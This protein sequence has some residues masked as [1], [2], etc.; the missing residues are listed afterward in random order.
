MKGLAYKC[1]M[2]KFEIENS[3]YKM[4]FDNMAAFA[5]EVSKGF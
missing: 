3:E 2:E 5:L 1:L 4:G